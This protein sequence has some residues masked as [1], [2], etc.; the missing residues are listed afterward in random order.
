V[1]GRV[2]GRNPR[3]WGR[4]FAAIG[5]VLVVGLAA[6][7]AMTERLRSGPVQSFDTAAAAP[8]Q[9]E[10]TT[11]LAVQRDYAHAW[12][13]LVSALEG[14]RADLLN[15]NFTG[16]ARE[17]WQDAILTQRQ[18]GLSRHIV[19]HGHAL[20]VTFYSLDGSAMEATDTADLEVEYREGDKLLTSERVLAHYL[21]LLTPTEDSWKIRVLQELPPG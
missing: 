11:A 14:N 17:Q 6:I 1:I 18:N 4:W 12:L 2:V 10:E 5:A 20:R 8:R 13:S 9:V 16:V 7:P 19:D 21:V 3:K 15:E